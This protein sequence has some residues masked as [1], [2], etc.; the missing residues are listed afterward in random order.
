MIKLLLI[1]V[2]LSGLG[3]GRDVVLTWEDTKNPSGTTW[4]VYRANSECGPAVVFAVIAQ[5][6]TEKTFTDIDREPGTYCYAATA[7]FNNVESPQSNESEVV[8][9]ADAPENFIAQ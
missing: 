9:K 7:V 6:L 2:L 5:G 3:Y 1:F 8:V 4:N